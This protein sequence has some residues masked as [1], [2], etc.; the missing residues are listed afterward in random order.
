MTS[1]LY[2]DYLHGI[3]PLE[4]S[5]VSSLIKCVNW[6]GW[7]E[8]LIQTGEIGEGDREKFESIFKRQDLE[9]GEEEGRSFWG[10]EERFERVELTFRTY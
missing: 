7:W 1:T 8:Y 4:V 5:P 10:I 9:V 6:E 2:S 3:Q